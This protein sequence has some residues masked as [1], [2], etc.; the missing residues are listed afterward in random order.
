MSS[1]TL[2]SMADYVTSLYTVAEGTGR[3]GTIAAPPP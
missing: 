2:A 1:V 3:E